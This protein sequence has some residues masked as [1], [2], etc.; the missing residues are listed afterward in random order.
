MASFDDPEWTYTV[1]EGDTLESIAQQFS[2]TVPWLME[3]NN[4]GD[5]P[6]TPGDALRV[7]GSL[8]YPIDVGLYQSPD[9]TDLPGTLV[10]DGNSLLFDPVDRSRPPL[11][12]NLV[13]RLESAQMPHPARG[14]VDDPTNP[15]A[16]WLLVLTHLRNRNDPQSM[17]T[18]FFTGK[19]SDIDRYQEEIDRVA[20][21]AQKMDKFVAPDPNKIQGP[22]KPRPASRLP[23]VEVEGVSAILDRAQISNIRKFVPL[24]FRKLNW[25]LVYQLSKDGCSL[26]SLYDQTSHSE[27]LVLVVLTAHGDRFGA[28]LPIGLRDAQHYYGT[29]ETFV[30]RVTPSFE[31]FTWNSGGNKFFTASSPTELTVGGGEGCALFIGKDMLDGCSGRCATFGSPPLATTE[32]FRIVNVEAWQLGPR[33][34]RRR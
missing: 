28:Y 18:V 30:F 26:T 19:K 13:G 6:I 8:I 24:R 22:R 7:F 5:Q 9:S 25:K 33:V 12:I 1:V 11:V 32:T 27:P 31:V 21:F 14:D 23:T 16:I 20:K 4:L 29:G 15:N 2:L 10:L 3:A 34:I 17:E